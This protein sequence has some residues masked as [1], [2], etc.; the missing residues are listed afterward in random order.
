MNAALGNIIDYPH[1]GGKKGTLMLVYHQTEY[2]GQRCYD[3]VKN[4]LK[5][6]I[7]KEISRRHLERPNISWPKITAQRFGEIWCADYTR[8]ILFGQIIYIAVI[9]DDFSHFYLGYNVSDQADTKLV[10]GAL[11]MALKTCFG[12]LPKYYMLNDQ[13]SPYKAEVYQ[14]HIA[15]NDIEQIFIP[16]G[17][18]WN[19]GEAEVGMKDIKA[20]FYKEYA[21]TCRAKNL[22]IVTQAQMMA[23]GIF[24]E[25]NERIPRPKLKGVTPMDVVKGRAEAKRIRMKNFAQDRIEGRNLKTKIYDLNNH[26]IE[27]LCLENFDNRQLKNVDNL[28]NRHYRKISPMRV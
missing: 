18:P 6:I 14:E 15:Q 19:N 7:T 2:I 5:Q 8:V 10:D 4:Q 22:D 9:L 23:K 21:H 17:T 28:L 27:K 25:L 3:F 1:M 13:D 24:K 16:K 20:L 11:I 26:I 12:V